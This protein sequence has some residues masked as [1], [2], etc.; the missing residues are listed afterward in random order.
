MRSGTYNFK[1]QPLGRSVHDVAITSKYC[2][3]LFAYY[4]FV[5]GFRRIYSSIGFG[6]ML[7]PLNREE[8]KVSQITVTNEDETQL[9]TDLETMGGN[10]LW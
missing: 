7:K 4:I 3:F 9:N 10:K 1:N 5:C 6:T 2:I 8:P